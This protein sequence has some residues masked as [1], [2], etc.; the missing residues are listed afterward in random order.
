MNTY[1]VKQEY[2]VETTFE[3]REIFILCKDCQD[4]KTK[5]RQ[6][7]Q[8]CPVFHVVIFDGLRCLLRSEG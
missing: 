2:F 8:E 3:K 1:L 4:F 7:F 6:L 5:K